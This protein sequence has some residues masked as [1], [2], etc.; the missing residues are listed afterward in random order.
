[1][2][3]DYRLTTGLRVLVHVGRRSCPAESSAHDMQSRQQ[4]E[5]LFKSY[6]QQRHRKTAFMLGELLMF[7]S[8]CARLT[9][10][11]VTSTEEHD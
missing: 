11:W 5:M 3:L 9:L 7:W 8:I 2:D 10:L 1:M 6:W 4:R